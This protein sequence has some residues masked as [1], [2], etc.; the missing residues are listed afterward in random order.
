[1]GEYLFGVKVSKMKKYKRQNLSL[2]NVEASKI[3][4]LVK[5]MGYLF[6]KIITKHIPGVTILM[7]KLEIV[8]MNA[9]I[10]VNY[11][12]RKS[13]Y[14]KLQKKKDSEKKFTKSA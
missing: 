14:S 12:K 1:M 3:Y 2:S 13:E 8:I 5:V 9:L 7:A 4:S 6:G 10:I 11:N